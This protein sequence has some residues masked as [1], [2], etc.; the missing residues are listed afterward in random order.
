MPLANVSIGGKIVGLMIDYESAISTV[1]SVNGSNYNFL[2]S[3]TESMDDPFR[4]R[5]GSMQ[6]IGYYVND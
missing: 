6:A 1:L 2:N 3:S 4:Y 5:D